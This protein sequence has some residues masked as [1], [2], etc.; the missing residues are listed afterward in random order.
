MTEHEAVRSLVGMM[1][2]IKRTVGPAIGLTEKFWPKAAGTQKLLRDIYD[3][4]KF[5][6]DEFERL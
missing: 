3:Y 4:A 1:E 5:A 6:Q 2:K